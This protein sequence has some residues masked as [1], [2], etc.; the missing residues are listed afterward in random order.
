M[1]FQQPRDFL[2]SEPIGKIESALI[3]VNTVLFAKRFHILDRIRAQ[4]VPTLEIL[5]DSLGARQHRID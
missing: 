2:F 5:P 3:G 1:Q 4:Y